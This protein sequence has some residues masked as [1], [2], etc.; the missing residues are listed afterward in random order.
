MLKHLFIR[1]FTLIDEL[2]MEFGSG[3]SVITGETGAGKSIILGAI[4]LLLGQRAD[5][6]TIK[7]GTDK[8]VVEAHFDLTAY[9]EMSSLFEDN[10]IEPDLADTIVRREL[11]AS[12][13][14]RAFVNDTPVALT[15]LKELGDRLIDIHSQHQNLLLG[16]HDFQLGVVDVIAADQKELAD[17]QRAFDAEYASTQRL[18]CALCLRSSC[19][20]LSL[21]L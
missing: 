21:R 1:N 18:P 2:D 7:Q 9:D 17:Y 16:K 3:F 14:S 13:K 12:G 15:V 20:L 8:C 11:T 6:K 5:M 10:D 19:G 4:G